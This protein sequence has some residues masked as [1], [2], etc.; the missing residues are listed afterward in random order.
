MDKVLPNVMCKY[1]KLPQQFGS[2]IVFEGTLCS[3]SATGRVVHTYRIGCVL[4]SLGDRSAG[5][6]RLRSLIFH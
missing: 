2:G 1:A 4:E 3:N 6:H 5:R